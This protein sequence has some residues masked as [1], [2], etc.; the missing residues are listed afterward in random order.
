M[1]VAAEGTPNFE[2]VA[3]AY[4]ASTASGELRETSGT[5]K[6]LVRGIVFASADDS[7]VCT[8]TSLGLVM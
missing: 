7:K 8:L 2:T 3:K 4:D 1:P 5:A 6:I